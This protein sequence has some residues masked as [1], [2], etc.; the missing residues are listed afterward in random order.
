MFYSQFI[1]AKKG[2]LGTIWIAAHLERKLRKNQVADTDIGVS[3]DSIIFPDVPIALRLSSHLMLGVVRIYSRKVNYLFHDCSEALLK[4]KQAF[5]STAVDLPPEESTAPYHSI[6]L[7]ETFHLDDF[8]LPEAA[9]QGDIDH[10]VSTKEQIT[11]QDNPERTGYSTSQFGL[12][13]RFGDGNSSHIGLDLDEELMLNKDH[14]IHLESD[15][16]IIIQGRPLVPSIDMDVDD[17]QSKDEV[18]EGYSNMDDGP[19]SHRKLSP[20]IADVIGGN[21]F[22]NWNGYNVQTP[23]LNDMLLQ[24][25]SIVGPSASYYQPSPFPCDEPA[26]PEFVSAQAPATPGL[27]EE[28][29]PSRVHESPVLS[30]QRKASPSINDETAKADTPA[31][32]ASDFLHPTTANASDVGAEMTE[33]A[34]AKP[35]QVESSV[36]LQDIDSLR[37][38]CTIE[39]LPPQCQTSNLEASVDKLAISTDDMTASG[40]PIIAKTT[41]EDVPWVDPEPSVMENP[42]QINEPLVDAQDF[43]QKEQAM[44][45]EV[46]SNVRPNEQSTSEFAEPEKMLSAPDDEFNQANDLGQLTAEKGIAES[47]GSN[48]IG[49][50]TSKKRHLEDSLPALESETTEKLSSRPHGKRTTDF[51][52]DDDDLLAS[53]LVGRRTPGLT[54][55]STPLPPRASSLKRPR[56]GSK[57]PTLKRKVQLDDAMVLHADT[58]RQQLI[59]TED[60]RRIRKKAPCTRSEIWMIEKGSLEDDI[61]RKPIFSCL[62]EELNNS[63]NRTYEIVELQVQPAMSE[64]IVE[65]INNV[66]TSD[67]NGIGT[68]DDLLHIPDG[69]QSDAVQ[70]AAGATAAL[71]LQILPD[72]QVNGVSN[73]FVADIVFQGVTE[74]LIDTEKEVALADRAHAQVDTLDN[75]HLQDVP[76]DLQHS[77]DTKVS[78][79]DV[80]RDSSGQDY[81]QAADNMTGDFNH[82]VHSD[83]NVIE[84]NEVP[85]SEITGVE[86]NQDAAGLAPPTEDENTLSAM[87]DNS[88]LQENNMGPLMDLDMVHDFALKEC[89]DF[90]SAIHG[91]D[92]D[93][94]NYD[95]DGDYD[96]A[97]NDEP[98]PD[99][100]QSLDNSGWSSRTRGVAKYLKTLFDEE[101]G[102][103]RKS[104]AI[105][106]LL[107]GKTRKE[108]SRMFFETLVLTTKDY[109][110]VEQPSPFDFVSIKPGPKLLKSDF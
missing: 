18:A 67:A 7:P 63:H 53:I 3:V 76:S 47:D 71:G 10:H 4:I 2:P 61:F 23:D 105:D 36:V 33:H 64:T 40:E 69:T 35:V 17:N 44:Q 109:I 39:D 26:S 22:P 41:R 88:G 106:R 104:V 29:V 81:A 28:T 51:V 37:Q 54:L 103:G 75:D 93:F 14:S 57:I 107:S 55:G 42:A 68:I 73:D 108:A 86:C 12:D 56:L 34:L 90:G 101:S 5:R 89:N 98:N 79:P 25:E 66:G 58:I 91:V 50:L 8:E 70:P 45:K 11:L 16:G 110:N 85:T 84:N 77:T 32:P 52:P 27:M 19:S 62:S 60:I 31:A 6:T 49:S 87:G 20:P 96:D 48:K 9:F 80:V 30:P 82:F 97:N 78:S 83:V 92:T 13:E 65:D 59:N 24:N 100:F 43:Q 99:E 72:N 94:L 95:D 46:A 102:L 74:P 21:N 38:Q 15:D 1:L